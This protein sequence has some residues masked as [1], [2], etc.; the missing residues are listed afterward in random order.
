MCIL[1]L[2]KHG[3]LWCGVLLKFIRRVLCLQKP[4]SLFYSGHFHALGFK[5]WLTARFLFQI[6][7]KR[8]VSF[9]LRIALFFF[10]FTLAKWRGCLDIHRWQ[11]SEVLADITNGKMTMLSREQPLGQ[12]VACVIRNLTVHRRPPQTL[13][14]FWWTPILV[15]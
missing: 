11:R 12:T 6:C 2:T 1:K 9:I 5:D 10:F 7:L 14:V 8:S 15:S 4:L 13:W 3:I